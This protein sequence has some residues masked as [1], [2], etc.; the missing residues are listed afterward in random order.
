M[1]KNIY[2][3]WALA[4]WLQIGLHET[5]I[6]SRFDAVRRIKKLQLGYFRDSLVE[7]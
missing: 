5:W 4:E 1:G 3:T 7:I 6:Y 2:R